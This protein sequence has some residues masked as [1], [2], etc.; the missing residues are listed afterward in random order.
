MYTYLLFEKL[1]TLQ[2]LGGQCRFSYKRG[3][4]G[5]TRF[6]PHVAVLGAEASWCYMYNATLKVQAWKTNNP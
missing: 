4:V 6:T 3:I 2:I 5:S 1:S